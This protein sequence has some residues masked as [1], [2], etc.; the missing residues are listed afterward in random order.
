[1]TATLESV[2]SVLMAAISLSGVRFR[3]QHNIILDVLIINSDTSGQTSCWPCPTNTTTD[4][5]GASSLDMCK[6]HA[7]PFY[8]KV[9]INNI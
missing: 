6:S 9:S 2:S 3:I 7:C 1:M 8:A 4:M 5:A